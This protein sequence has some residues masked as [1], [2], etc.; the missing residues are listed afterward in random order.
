MTY[1]KMDPRLDPLRSNEKF[2]D[3]L[4]NMNFPQ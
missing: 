1:L 2:K 4:R 3:L